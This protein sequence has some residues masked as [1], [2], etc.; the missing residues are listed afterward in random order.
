MDQLKLSFLYLTMLAYSVNSNLHPSQKG[1]AVVLSESKFYIFGPTESPLPWRC[2]VL[3]Q[4]A[5][6][7]SSFTQCKIICLTYAIWL[8]TLITMAIAEGRF[9]NSITRTAYE[10]RSW[11]FDMLKIRNLKRVDPSFAGFRVCTCAP[12]MVNGARLI[13][14]SGS[15]N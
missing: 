9:N 7:W 13:L 1:Q 10:C 12:W 11:S 6:F 5:E 15:S 2:P 4:S 8:C 14:P 3:E